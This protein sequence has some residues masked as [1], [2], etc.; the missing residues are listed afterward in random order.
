MVQFALVIPIILRE[1]DLPVPPAGRPG[2][3][4]LADA[5]MLEQ[6]VADVGFRDVET[7]TVTAVYETASSGLHPMD[8]GRGTSAREPDEGTTGCRSG[9]GMAEGHRRL[10]AAHD[11]CGQGTNHEPGRGSWP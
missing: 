9:T 4:A 10:G 11:E 8:P 2:P 5:R 7:G 1:L 6:L 3:F